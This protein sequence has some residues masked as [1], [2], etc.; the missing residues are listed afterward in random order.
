MSLSRKKNVLPEGRNLVNSIIDYNEFD[1]PTTILYKLS[2]NLSRSGERQP[3]EFISL[4]GDNIENYTYSIV[5]VI[6]GLKFNPEEE[7]VT[8]ASQYKSIRQEFPNL[9]YIDL[10]MLYKSTMDLYRDEKIKYKD[11]ENND[12]TMPKNILKSINN[13]FDTISEDENVSTF[14]FVNLEGLD[15]MYETWLN[16]KDNKA[17]E[18]ED[19]Y[20]KLVDVQ[21]QLAE[22]E[23]LNYDDPVIETVFYF[24]KPKMK[25]IYTDEEY[26]P[27]IE[28]GIEIFKHSLVSANVPFIQYN[29]NEGQQYYWL[30]NN[31][32][33][34]SKV[35]SP[36]IYL[37]LIKQQT[38]INTIY[39]LLWGG[40]KKL[41]RCIYYIDKAELTLRI[42]NKNNGLH[43]TKQILQ[44]ALPL[45]I[46][47]EGI[48]TKVQ[49]YFEVDQ[50]VINEPLAPVD[51]LPQPAPGGAAS[52]GGQAQ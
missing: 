39:I 2:Y 8:L 40:E 29:N 12:L 19:E 51:L 15:K 10:A 32:F 47:D 36:T 28:E 50:I 22:I 20:S 14:S 45:I 25:S 52:G 3:I 21:E 26:Q 43:T 4:D 16:N 33:Q 31:T 42:S 30:Y 27:D 18:Q 46:L 38:R 35:E 17:M 1:N 6:Y 23:P 24:Y 48:Q 49:G 44:K 5:Q 41:T 37:D 13:M 9:D 11:E 7:V 34:D